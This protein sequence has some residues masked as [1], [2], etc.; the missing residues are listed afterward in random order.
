M[1]WTLAK[2][3]KL[4]FSQPRPTETDFLEQHQPRYAQTE[5]EPVDGKKAFGPNHRVQLSKTNPSVFRSN[6]IWNS[7]QDL[8]NERYKR[9]KLPNSLR[10]LAQQK[11]IA[12]RPKPKAHDSKP[13]TAD[14][15]DCG[16][17]QSIATETL[18]LYDPQTKRDADRAN[19]KHSSIR[20]HRP[21][22][23]HFR[24]IKSSIHDYK[25]RA[26][27]NQFNAALVG[28]SP[29][30][31]A[32]QFRSPAKSKSKLLTDIKAFR[33]SFGN[34]YLRSN[35]RKTVSKSCTKRA[36]EANRGETLKKKNTNAHKE[37]AST[38]F[39]R[40]QR[41][42][43]SSNGLPVHLKSDSNRSL[44]SISPKASV[45]ANLGSPVEISVTESVTDETRLS[46]SQSTVQSLV[47]GSNN[48][49]QPDSNSRLIPDLQLEKLNQWQSRDE[50]RASLAEGS[51][52]FGKS[53]EQHLVASPANPQIDDACSSSV[54]NG[55]TENTVQ[56]H[57]AADSRGHSASQ[58]TGRLEP[59]CEF[60]QFTKA[61]GHQSRRYSEQMY[62]DIRPSPVAVSTSQKALQVS[63][64][65][66]SKSL[67]HSRVANCDLENENTQS[68]SRA[69]TISR[70]RGLRKN[71]AA[72]RCSLQN[73][74]RR[75]NQSQSLA[76]QT[77]GTQP[78]RNAQNNVESNNTTNASGLLLSGQDKVSRKSTKQTQTPEPFGNG[79][80]IK[81]LFEEIAQSSKSTLDHAL[82][83]MAEQSQTN[84]LSLQRC[85]EQVSARQAAT[86]PALE[87][88][89]RIDKI[90]AQLENLTQ[91][92][93]Q[94]RKANSEQ[95]LTIVKI[96][97]QLESQKEI[98]SLK[99][100]SLRRETKSELRWIEQSF[101]RALQQRA[102]ICER[103]RSQIDWIKEQLLRQSK[104]SAELVSKMSEL[105]ANSKGV[106]LWGPGRVARGVQPNARGI[107]A[108]RVQNGCNCGD[109]RDALESPP[110]ASNRTGRANSAFIKQQPCPEIVL[111]SRFVAEQKS[112]P[113]FAPQRHGKTPNKR[114]HE[115]EPNQPD[116]RQLQASRTSRPPTRVRANKCSIA[117]IN[118]A[119]G[120]AQSHITN[121][122]FKLPSLKLT[123]PQKKDHNQQQPTGHER[124]VHIDLDRDIRA[125]DHELSSKRV[126]SSGNSEIKHCYSALKKSRHAPIQP[127][128]WPSFG[129][130]TP[131]FFY[132]ETLDSGP[133]RQS[134]RRQSSADFFRALAEKYSLPQKNSP[135]QV[136]QSF[137]VDYSKNVFLDSGSL[138][139]ATQATR[140][141][142]SQS[143]KLLG[144]PDLEKR[145]RARAE[146]ERE[147]QLALYNES[148]SILNCQAM[149]TGAGMGRLWVN[150][151][152]PNT[153]DRP[154]E[155][156]GEGSAIGR[157]SHEK[158]S[159]RDTQVV[160]KLAEQRGN[161]EKQAA[162]AHPVKPIEI[163]RLEPTP[164]GCLSRQSSTPLLDDHGDQSAIEVALP[165]EQDQKA[166]PD[167]HLLTG[168]ALEKDVNRKLL[169]FIANHDHVSVSSFGSNSQLSD[170][171]SGETP[172]ELSEL[173]PNA[174]AKAG[175]VVEPHLGSA[176][177]GQTQSVVGTHEA[178]PKALDSQPER[179]QNCFEKTDSAL[180]ETEQQFGG[181][182]VKDRTNAISVTEKAP[183]KFDKALENTIKSV[184]N[185]GEQN[186]IVLSATFLKFLS[187][188]AITH[189]V[190]K[191]TKKN[192]LSMSDMDFVRSRKKDILYKSKSLGEL[193][194]IMASCVATSHSDVVFG[195]GTCS[196]F[197]TSKRRGLE[198]PGEE[199]P[200]LIRQQK[201]NEKGSGVQPQDEL[202]NGKIEEV[203]SETLG[204]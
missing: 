154:D 194:I 182:P 153:A 109:G 149:R 45:Q 160:A 25:K 83:K 63:S 70:Q 16:A 15:N 33:N 60:G 110:D 184:L 200:N 135:S 141:L 165:N 203:E 2:T 11:Q 118:S 145:T 151:E 176:G 130:A 150:A 80:W 3:K 158:R 30:G 29:G 111:H 178:Q 163:A 179:L 123:E 112:S 68:R 94:L 1:N 47:D 119:N 204:K 183:D 193:Q 76:K 133:L 24:R 46:Q 177:D 87:S 103:Q 155:E 134:S 49:Y 67:E 192:S 4:R 102:A 54:K 185:P 156:V 85:L 23:K 93:E 136:A 95:A 147:R 39:R 157:T 73:A 44:A 131:G 14:K 142:A 137:R 114:S 186:R 126:D 167:L 162:Q 188:Q 90:E 72:S 146:A 57:Q 8:S 201:S 62:L 58:S 75:T 132:V 172:S 191:V 6:Q 121:F 116:H 108:D 28:K 41:L 169:D 106:N 202:G 42:R 18:N 181:R 175:V 120:N 64:D 38:N 198:P 89:K 21:L 122:S 40:S 66:V 22:L 88:P 19:Q 196:P 51:Y 84:N 20:K 48:I 140:D 43:R 79:A 99:Q 71:S 129:G 56:R 159:E 144:G 164:G 96:Q 35:I 168:I 170:T 37:N 125:A 127:G 174:R 197:D 105:D 113:Q 148:L 180:A 36:S 189:E 9:A 100:Q 124:L 107:I 65:R 171:L 143:P 190:K 139:E 152:S 34:M 12:S 77:R 81:R 32:K 104:T 173:R 50:P 53:S 101:G 17:T 195:S 82:H 187:N 55:I 52:G 27:P 78:T 69:P 10:Q 138:I 91:T 31:D 7:S 161:A 128:E 5:I 61:E 98:T 117:E 26:R 92:I 115:H 13:V 199:R 86:A 97:A 59:K 166:K 74:E